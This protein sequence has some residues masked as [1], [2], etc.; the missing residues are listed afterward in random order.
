MSRFQAIF[1]GIIIVLVFVAFLILSGFLP[2]MPGLGGGSEVPLSMWGT[3]PKEIVQ[4]PIDIVNKKNHKVFVLKYFEKNEATYEKELVDA[5]ASGTGPDIF[6]IDQNFVLKHQNKIF[7]FPFVSFTERKFKDTF[8]DEA[9]LFLTKD[10]IVA[11]PWL[12][13]PLVLYWNKDYFGKRGVVSVP[14]TWD[15]FLD[16]VIVL[17]LRDRSGNIL[18]SGAAMGE[19][20]NIENAKDI[21]SLLVLQ[22]GTKIIDKD[23]LDVT[24]NQRGSVSSA[25][26]E[27]ALAFYTGFSNPSKISYSW[28]RALPNSR[29]MFIAGKLAM[30]FGFASEYVSVSDSNPHLNFDVADVPQV[31]DAPLQA[32]FGKIYGLAVSKNS[33]YAAGQAIAAVYGMAMSDEALGLM[34]ENAKLPPARRDILSAGT[35]D[36]VLA[37]FYKGAIQAKGWLEPDSRAVSDMVEDM[38]DSVVSGKKNFSKAVMDMLDL[39]RAEIEPIKQSR[40]AS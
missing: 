8:V 17:T 38:I 27:S 26:A 25:P 23:T 3:L 4:R 31:K 18:E 40:M 14:K 15:D 6:L 32:T 34:M 13:D 5:L 37:V 1:I 19:F 7:L 21:F 20:K 9:E 2:G 16:K 36:S 22:G 30:Y 11:L 29:D 12:V 39:L 24:F 35:L 33:S 28:N 10:G